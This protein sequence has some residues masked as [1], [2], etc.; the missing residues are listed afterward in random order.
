MSDDFIDAHTTLQDGSVTY[1]IWQFLNDR[2]ATSD[3]G[4]FLPDGQV[5]PNDRWGDIVDSVGTNWSVS[6]QEDVCDL[7]SR[8]VQ[9]GI[10]LG[11]FR[12]DT[13]CHERLRLV[14]D[15]FAGEEF[16]DTL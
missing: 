3:E 5:I 13:T 12:K 14:T 7:A 2:S 1:S 15:P 16:M 9:A 11:L 8:I 6:S 10:T 4:V